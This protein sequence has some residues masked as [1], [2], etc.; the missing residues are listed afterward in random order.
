ML[1]VE[2]RQ[3]KCRGPVSVEEK[4]DDTNRNVFVQ[5]KKKYEF[6]LGIRYY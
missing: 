3:R 5:M 1:Y 6:V 4:Y 2:A